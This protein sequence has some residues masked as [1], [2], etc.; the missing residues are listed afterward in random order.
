MRKPPQQCKNSLVTDRWTTIAVTESAR[1]FSNTTTHMLISFTVLPKPFLSVFCTMRICMH[2]GKA[3]NNGKPAV[4]AVRQHTYNNNTYWF[5]LSGL[6]SVTTRPKCQGQNFFWVA[7]RENIS[8][9]LSTRSCSNMSAQQ[10]RQLGKSVTIRESNQASVVAYVRCI[11]RST[12]YEKAPF[13]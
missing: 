8:T 13:C 10:W 12:M 7:S 3:F 11:T 6:K 4:L 5:I 9:G 2:K 1:M